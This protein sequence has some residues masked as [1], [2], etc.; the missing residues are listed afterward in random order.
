MRQYLLSLSLGIPLGLLIGLIMWLFNQEEFPL[1]WPLL[2]GIIVGP[3][4][5]GSSI[6]WHRYF[7][8][9]LGYEINEENMG[10][11]HTRIITLPLAIN[12][13]DDICRESLSKIPKCRLDKRYRFVPKIIGHAGF[14]IRM[15]GPTWCL[16]YV[17]TLGETITFDLVKVDESQTRVI[18]NSKPIYSWIFVD[19]GK[20]LQN[21]EKISHALRRSKP[22]EPIPF[23]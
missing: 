10:V 2:I 20:S 9:D 18:V 7:V 12:N 14:M 16:Y 19:Y 15:V 23:S 8:R 21:I 5:I 11:N 22:R 17:P 13:V 4:G 3:F 6:F 1:W